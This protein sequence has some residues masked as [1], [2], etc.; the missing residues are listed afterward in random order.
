M[1]YLVHQEKQNVQDG[2]DFL[3]ASFPDDLDN[4]KVFIYVDSNDV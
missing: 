3:D 2:W 4:W 1:Y